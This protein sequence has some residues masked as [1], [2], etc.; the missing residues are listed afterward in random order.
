M[1]Y[2]LTQAA[3]R[4]AH[5]TPDH[6]AVRFNG[7][8]LTWADLATAADRLARVLTDGGV[9][10]GDRVGIFM[11][12]RLES[13]VAIHGIMKAG[14]AYVPIDPAAPAGRVSFILR[15]C[16]IRHV[17][18]D[19]GRLG[20]L[21]DAIAAGARVDRLIGVGP[22][23]GEPS[24]VPW[25]D[26]ASAPATPAANG[27]M[28]QDLAYVLYTSGSTG[29]PKGV[30]HTHRS[31]LS[32]AEIAVREY[33]LTGEDR[34]SNHAPLHFD[35]S[36]LDYFAAAVAG[37]TTVVIPESHTKLPASLS[38]LMETERLTVLYAVPYALIQ[39][40]LNGALDKRSLPELRL[41]LFGGEPFPPKHLRALMAVLPQACFFNV[42]GP[43][44]VN[45]VTH[46][47]V[48]PLT[49]D[50]VPI[51]IGRPYGNV[52]ALIVDAEDR[53]VPPGETGLLLVRTPTMMR[54]Y[55]GRADLN[56]NAFYRRP[57]FG[58][59]EDVFHRTGDIVRERPDGNL[60]F[61]GRKDRQIKARGYRVELD[62]I[63]AALLSHDAVESAAAYVVPSGDGTQRIEAAVTLRADRQAQPGEL[64]RHA[65]EHLP[66]YAVP[67][68]VSV[69]SEF[70]RTS[71]DKIDR[72]R[73]Q[74]MAAE[75]V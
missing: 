57:V 47:P 14:A 60:E 22:E 29:E 11:P 17:I 31:A 69:L 24:G 58:L 52:E 71:T 68:R 33:S 1:L 64:T 8:P 70:P 4:A 35:L 66:P 55:W 13:A 12:K 3:D 9:R 49:D 28:E 5:R 43:T 48:P 50:D 54:G 36:T 46:F 30:M 26:V 44:E 41:I 65:A 21:H 45:G 15:D 10:R 56:A 59:Y 37:A 42:Y 72:L 18:T 53:P 40:L 74:T 23:D 67:E 51:P 75:A 25:S 6:A 2:L 16:G 20:V 27:A 63:E 19:R 62:E 38:K 61:L 32:F 39:L 73:L 7:Q 34:L